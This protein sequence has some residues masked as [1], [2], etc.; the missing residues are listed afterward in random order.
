MGISFDGALS[1][2]SAIHD[3]TGLRALIEQLD[4]A[5][6]QSAKVTAL[7]SGMQDGKDSV[8]K[9]LVPALERDGVRTIGTTDAGKFLENERFLN[10]VEEIFGDDPIHS[11]GKCSSEDKVKNCNWNLSG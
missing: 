8:G 5:G 7:W 9:N 6:D 1:Q 2:L 4:A 11:A 10:K 3:E